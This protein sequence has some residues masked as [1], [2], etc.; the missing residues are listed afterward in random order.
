MDGTHHTA[1]R[2]EC[3]Q[4]AEE[5]GAE[6]EPDVPDLHH[7]ALLLHHDGVK[8]SGASEPGKQRSV[9][10]RIPTPVTAPTEN[11]VSPVSAKQDA[12]RLEAP[13]DHGPFAG[14]MNPLFPGIASEQSRKSKRERDG[15]ARVTGI[16][17]RRMN[18]HLRILEERIQAVAVH[19]GEGF[20][21]AAGVDGG[22]SL[23]GI[24][25]EIV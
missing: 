15:E 10:H 8:E 11:R 4:N 23:E 2:E 22:E 19:A 5:E 12:E 3:S 14:E 25:D 17:V 9:F 18:H 6:H 21:D 20:E 24:L 13:S 16:E 7:A 1:A